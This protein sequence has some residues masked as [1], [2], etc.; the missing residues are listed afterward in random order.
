MISTKGGKFGWGAPAHRLADAHEHAWDQ[1]QAYVIGLR[2]AV[3][4]IGNGDTRARSE[5]RAAIIIQRQAL[6]NI[7]SFDHDYLSTAAS[8][9]MQHNM[10]FPEETIIS[11]HQAMLVGA[12][13]AQL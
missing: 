12:A 6:A 5:M 13:L 7:D 2:S 10:Q 3:E 1:M 11:A 9:I 4:R 8:E